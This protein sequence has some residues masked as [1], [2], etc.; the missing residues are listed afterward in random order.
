MVV[1]PTPGPGRMLFP[2]PLRPGRRA[3][4]DLP[5]DLT[6]QEAKKVANVVSALASAGQL[7]ITAG[8]SAE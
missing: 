2:I 3:L 4:L 7:A 8:T 1:P 6:E 5:E